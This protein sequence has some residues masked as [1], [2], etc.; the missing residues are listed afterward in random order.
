MNLHLDA[1]LDPCGK[2]GVS[3]E[4]NWGGWGGD[5]AWVLCIH[6]RATGLSPSKSFVPL[7]QS[8]LDLPDPGE[9]R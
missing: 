7:A 8:C 5:G 9:A 3:C 4:W 1:K 2:D 6:N